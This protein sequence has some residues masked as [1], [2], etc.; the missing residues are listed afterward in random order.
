MKQKFCQVVIRLGAFVGVVALMAT[1]QIAFADS[2]V[3]KPGGKVQLTVGSVEATAW[4]GQPLW[5]ATSINVKP[6][7][8]VLP[9]GQKISWTMEKVDYDHPNKGLRVQG[10]WSDKKNLPENRD[11]NIRIEFKLP[12][13][14]RLLGKTLS[15]DLNMVIVYQYCSHE[16]GWVNQYGRPVDVRIAHERSMRISKPVT[17][18]VS[19]AE[20]IKGNQAGQLRFF[21]L[22]A[23]GILVFLALFALVLHFV[24]QPKGLMK[25]LNDWKA[26]QLERIGSVNIPCPA[27]K[28]QIALSG[29]CSSCGKQILVGRLWSKFLLLLVPAFLILMAVGLFQNAGLFYYMAQNL[30]QSGTI[31]LVIV[32]VLISIARHAFRDMRGGM[33]GLA[34]ALLLPSPNREKHLRLAN[35]IAADG[36]VSDETKAQLF[37]VAL[38]QPYVPLTEWHMAADRSC[39]L[40]FWKEKQSA[41]SVTD[42]TRDV[43][44]DL[45]FVDLFQ[46]CMSRGYNPQSD[47]RVDGMVATANDREP[48]LKA[49]EVIQEQSSEWTKRFLGHVVPKFAEKAPKLATVLSSGLSPTGNQT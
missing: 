1:A 11:Y 22:A 26:A 43:V 5:K 21:I 47:A 23:G 10:D 2:A 20:Q 39:G 34:S 6:H 31:G 48:L 45:T 14:N 49:A 46:D 9:D 32:I 41:P 17:F 28:E 44:N 8:L 15:F 30:A 25:S 12:D 33:S 19:T 37:G 3:I 27:C 38:C 13:D 24:S 7:P 29:V 18:T 35:K 4:V 40:T 16:S 36:S 42:A